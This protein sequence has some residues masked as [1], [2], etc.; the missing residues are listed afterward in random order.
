MLPLPTVTGQGDRKREAQLKWARKGG[1]VACKAA[2][3]PET[4]LRLAEIDNALAL[5]LAVTRHA[6]PQAK[7][8]TT[9]FS[10][11]RKKRGVGASGLPCAGQKDAFGV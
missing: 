2:Q 8:R 11:R 9:K 5:A 4:A 6:R 1:V 10:S 7:G 3:V